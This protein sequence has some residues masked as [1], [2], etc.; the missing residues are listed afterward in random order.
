M[1]KLS[2][3][4]YGADRTT[5]I[6]I[7][8]SLIRSNCDYGSAVA[9]PNILNRLNLIHHTAI[10]LATGA[11]RTSLVSGEWSLYFKRKQTIFNMLIH[12]RSSLS[13]PVS[14]LLEERCE[15]NNFH[16][17]NYATL[18]LKTAS[19]TLPLLFHWS[20][21]VLPPWDTSPVKYRLHTIGI[22][23]KSSPT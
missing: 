18:I 14:N 4:S 15:L 17:L 16:F 9:T 5:L 23:K 6:H 13:T 19:T 3:I 2:H 11:F 21:S 20:Q 1:R 22:W 12:L 10:R 8:R 7:Y